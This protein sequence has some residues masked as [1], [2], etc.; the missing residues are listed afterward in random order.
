MAADYNARAGTG[1]GRIETNGMTGRKTAYR[2]FPDALWQAAL[3]ILLGSVAGLAVNAARGDG[4]PLV[5]SVRVVKYDIP[6]GVPPAEVVE[7]P[8]ARPVGDGTAEMPAAGPETEP[9]EPSGS[10]GEKTPP[11]SEPTPAAKPEARPES[12]GVEVFSPVPVAGPQD[13]GDDGGPKALGLDRALELYLGGT[14]VFVDARMPDEF[15]AGHI[16]GAVNLPYDDLESHL[17]VLGFLPEDGLVVTYCD[18]TECELSLELADE[19]T[20]MGFNQVRVFFGGWE[21][22]VEAGH[23]IEEGEALLPW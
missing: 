10:G 15:A 5:G 6:V 14:A 16:P 22:W 2:A 12:S 7:A 23:D 21:Q 8:A 4:I 1:A 3:I 20:A 19:L 18:G 11:V 9:A 17:D 13:G